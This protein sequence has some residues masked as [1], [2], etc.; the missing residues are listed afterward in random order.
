M[1]SRRKRGEE[2]GFGGGRRRGRKNFCF[3]FLGG[4]SWFFGRFEVVSVFVDPNFLE[5]ENK[6]IWFID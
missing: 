4:G 6:L 2:G 3:C 1:K 5:R